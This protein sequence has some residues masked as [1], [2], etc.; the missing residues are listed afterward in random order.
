VLRAVHAGA[1]LVVAPHPDARGRADALWIAGGRVVDWARLPDA[2]E[3]VATRTAEALRA[4][5]AVTSLGGWLPP[6]ELD[7]VRLVGGW[8]AGHGARV[9]ELHPAPSPGRVE[10]FV[11]AALA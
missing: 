2:R 4:A 8:L 10:A 6:D 5:P 3:E 9:L 7:E 1:R 11:S